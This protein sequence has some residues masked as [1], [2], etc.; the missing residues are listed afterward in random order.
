M[1]KKIGIIFSLVLFLFAAANLW[2]Y[3]SS[4]S[5]TVFS[6]ELIG[7]VSKKFKTNLKSFLTNVE[8][9]TTSIREGT[10]GYNNDSLTRDELNKVFSEQIKNDKF[11]KGVILF[12]NHINY[13]I[14]KEEK[15]WATT[16]STPTADSMLD[17]SRLDENLKV[18]SQWSDTYNFFMN[19]KNKNIISRN[20]ELNGKS[21]WRMAQ[22]EIP[23]KRELFVNIFEVTDSKK[24]KYIIGLL[25]K[26]S[27]IAGNFSSIFK[28]ENPLINIIDESGKLITPIRTS[29][30]SKITAYNK[31][32]KEVESILKNWTANKNNQPYS[33][34]FE[35][36]DQVFWM[37]IDTISNQTIKGFTI[38][39]SEN[40]IILSHQALLVKY[41]YLAIGLFV[42]GLIIL[43]IPFL[44]RRNQKTE[45]K[46]LEK[47]EKETVLKLISTGE[48]EFVEFK[49]SLR[50]DYRLEKENKI[51]EI[52]I[53]KSISAFA[54]AKGGTLFIGVDDDLNILGL[55]NDFNTLKKPDAD[56]FELHIRKLI[57][58][59]FGISFA[60]ENL[61]LY[62]NEFEKKQICVIQINASHAPLYL[63]IK[64]KQGQQIEKFYVRSGNSSQQIGSL[65][66]IN[67]YIKR[68]FKKRD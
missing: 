39:V 23:D 50:Y 35:K 51:L 48:T 45:I 10:V 16:Y 63:K 60:N 20:I 36:F 17:W 66:E 34:S 29:D 68:R 14:V 37:H 32:S 58:N 12:S 18:V 22:S 4:Q 31:L 25:Y 26:T 28:F 9:T 6:D 64:D 47:H 38:T 59:Q 15:T 19:E 41:L 21:V 49:S 54:N 56:Y 11:L 3:F 62:F 30:T 42:F 67:E 24:Q 5:N 13:V 46:P 57:N 2:N 8:N 52:V 40:D 7:S 44:K 33:Y 27:E 65:K 43:G 53:L 1:S 61:L 55:E